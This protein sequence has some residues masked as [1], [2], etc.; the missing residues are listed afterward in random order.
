M[1]EEQTTTTT[2]AVNSETSDNSGKTPLSLSFRLEEPKDYREVEELTRE[3]FWNGFQPGADEHYLLHILRKHADYIHDLSYLAIHREVCSE[4]GEVK[5]VI[6]GSI[7]YSKSQI[8]PLIE[9]REPLDTITFGPISVHPSYKKLGVGKALIHHTAKLA[10]EKGY[11]AIVILGDPGYYSRFGFRLGERYDLRTSSNKYAIGL[12]V[13]I[14]QKDLP[15]ERL[16]GTFHESHAFE[17]LDPAD[18]E[19]FDATFPE[20]EKKTGL[21]SQIRFQVLISLG[22][23]VVDTF[24][25]E[26]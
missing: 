26:K 6:V 2:A 21:D 23:P 12:Q 16:S 18:I 1:S 8:V 25:W 24:D 7:V 22:Y 15:L 9:G 11:P 13:M 3:A 19:A 5:E 10:K 4:T 14:L 20:K 17:E